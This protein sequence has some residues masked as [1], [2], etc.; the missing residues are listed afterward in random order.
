VVISGCGV[1]RSPP[2]PQDA[3][4]KVGTVSEGLSV[5]LFF[6]ATLSM[7]GF[8]TTQTTSGYQVTVPLLERGVIEGW[9]DGQVTFYKFGD[10]IA[11]L[12]GRQ[13]LDAV[14]TIFYADSKYNR[15]TLIER[16]IDRADP[17]HLTV[18]VTDLFQTNADINQL[19]EK[20]KQKF[21][22][23]DLSI[24]LYAIRSQ[25]AGPIYD[26]GPDAYSFK[27]T[28][29][30][31]ENERPFYLLAFGKHADIAHYFEVLDSAG[32]SAI[33]EKHTLIFSRYVTSQFPSFARAKLKVADR[34]SEI[35]ASNLLARQYDDDRIKA[36]KLSKSKPAAKFTAE[37]TCDSL[38]K[39]VMEYE[40]DLTAEISAWKSEDKGGKELS[41]VESPQAVKAF[42]VTAKLLPDQPPF[43]QLQIAANISI[44]D[45]PATGTYLYRILIRPRH[46][47]L[48]SWVSIWN[49]RDEEVKRWH[50][51]PPDFNGAKTYNL[52]NFLG[53]LQGAVLST[54]PPKLGDF[55]C[56]IRVD[57]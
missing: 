34:I 53:T 28:S 9:K 2:P 26:V 23:H 8:V 24:G 39:N 20:L 31:P 17:E 5:D 32:L 56:Y 16:V 40:N 25:F 10:D 33:G 47:L 57:K 7:Q 14:K 46:F 6:D 22:A 11:P 27:Y 55:Y 35:S 45:F 4:S 19:S 21:I 52:E 41:Q 12:P 44:T 48:P 50:Q 3:Y 15:R 18:I 36:F 51:H 54:T 43:S 1:K 49:M 29:T 42:Q 37:L 38:V 30:K 13:Y